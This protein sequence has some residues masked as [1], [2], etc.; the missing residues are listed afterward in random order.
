MSGKP[1][2]ARPT[3]DRDRAKVEIGGRLRA[4]RKARNVTIDAVAEAAGLTKGFLSRL[5]RDEVSPSVASLVT[6]CEVLRLRVGDLFDPPDTS[7]VRAGQGRP[8]NFGGDRATEH[9]VTPGTQQHIE[10]IHALIEGG[11]SGGTGL[12]TL[13]CEVE[14]AYVV[15]GRLEVVFEDH[16]DTLGPG[17][18]MTFPGKSLHTWRNASPDTAC[19]ALW[20]LAPAP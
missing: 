2:V 1:T 20:V 18:A 13:E 12:Y 3:R 9:L 4:A 19:E 7:V 11:G 16:V 8:I 15:S 10:I 6:L 5:E 14:C 17:D